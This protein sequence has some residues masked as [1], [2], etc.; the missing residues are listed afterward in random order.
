MGQA[1]SLS[2]QYKLIPKNLTLILFLKKLLSGDAALPA[3]GLAATIPSAS[4]KYTCDVNF[5]VV[6]RCGKGYPPYLVRAA[7]GALTR[8]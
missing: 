8:M 1:A 6:I 5:R 4:F 7:A 3:F 2:C